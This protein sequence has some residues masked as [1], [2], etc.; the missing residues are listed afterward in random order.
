V[1][2]RVGSTIT[3]KVPALR[4]PNMSDRNGRLL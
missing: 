3:Y 4:T 1:G 2:K